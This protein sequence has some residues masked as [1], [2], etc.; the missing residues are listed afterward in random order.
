MSKL[1]KGEV[2]YSSLCH[3]FKNTALTPEDTAKLLMVYSNSESGDRG[4]VESLLKKIIE[5]FHLLRK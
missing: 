2:I 3:F 5:D 4:W 1:G